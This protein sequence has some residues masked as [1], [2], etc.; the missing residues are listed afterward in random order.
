MAEPAMRVALLARPGTACD[1]LQAALQ[2]VGAE[3]VLVLDPTTSDCGTLLAS[4]P[5]AVLVALEPAVEEVLERFDAVLDDPDITVVFDEAELAASR[6][7][8]DAARWTRHL[9]AKLNR[10]DHVLP[11]GTEE[12]EPDFRFHAE[13]QRPD[14]Y[15][16]PDSDH[17][18]DAIPLNFG[19]EHGYEPP[20]LQAGVEADMSPARAAQQEDI[21]DLD[22]WLGET[23]LESVQVP[24]VDDARTSDRFRL[25]LDDIHVRTATLDL[26]Q[27][28]IEADDGPRTGAVVVI[29]GV[30][31]PDA[32]RQLLAAIPPR[33][34]RPLLVRQ[35]LDGG[36]HDRLVRQM[37]RATEM[38]VA[39]AQPGDALEP[40]HVYILPNAI[41]AALDGDVIRFVAVEPGDV[42]P[43]L[44]G[45]PA[46][47]SA[48]L[49]L[50]GSDPALVDE[51]LAQS[52]RGTLVAGQS[53]DGCFDGEAA[54]ALIARGGES[55]SP[56]ELA[57]RLSTRWLSLS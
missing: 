43:I 50:S 52:L 4:A 3:P 49:V 51:V 25:D 14:L 24:E 16:R 20:A 27:D 37:Q 26:P 17:D 34:P 8:W 44:L 28:R 48:I 32:V 46:A 12:S 10:H 5:Q 23:A 35:R 6:E 57:R 42:M 1:R 22:R 55:G 39:L 38:P 53:P 41:A 56:R 18:L 29:A 2:E 9:A 30:G 54:V 33:F 21:V 15:R 7:G 11:P 13:P 31:G 19:I 40:G 36:R 47:D 45:L